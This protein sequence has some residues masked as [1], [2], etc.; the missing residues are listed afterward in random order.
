MGLNAA[1][2]VLPPM[3]GVTRWRVIVSI[4]IMLLC[5]HVAWSCGWIPGVAGLAQADEIGP[6]ID[7]K[8]RPIEAK[9]SA[10]TTQTSALSE[11]VKQSLKSQYSEEIRKAITAR[12]NT[13]DPE[14][15][16]RI[17]ETIERYQQDYVKVAG[18]RYP[19]PSCE[20]T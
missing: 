13:E 17:N 16:R 18:E 5:G 10:L 8:L 3:D 7:E 12:C 19:M 1:K 14:E 4:S 15:R 2:E 9:L 11:L 6:K 20:D